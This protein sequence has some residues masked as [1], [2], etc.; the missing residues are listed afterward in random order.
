VSVS[1]DLACALPSEGSREDISQVLNE[2]L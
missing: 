2:M 1:W